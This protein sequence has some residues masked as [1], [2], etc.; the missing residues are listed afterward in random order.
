[1]VGRYLV[2]FLKKDFI[3]L[4]APLK[5]SWSCWF[6]RGESSR[7]SC[8]G[9]LGGSVGWASAFGLGRGLGVLGS[10]P[11]SG[12][13]HGGEPVSSLSLCL[14]LCLLVVSVCQINK[15]LKKRKKTSV[16]TG[17]SII[18]FLCN[19]GDV[20]GVLMVWNFAKCFLN[21]RIRKWLLGLFQRKRNNLDSKWEGGILG[22]MWGHF[23]I[24]AAHSM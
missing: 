1:M 3:Y 18:F 13:L 12:S 7:P 17:S 11:T 15:I 19:I 10:S 20:L 23:H 8:E 21:L 9:R 2:I 6:S 16:R 24:S 22:I 14:P 5:R 4:F